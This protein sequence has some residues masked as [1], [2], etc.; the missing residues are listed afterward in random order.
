MDRRTDIWTTQKPPTMA[1]ADASKT[2][3]LF[4]YVIL[5]LTTPDY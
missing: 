4:I 2:D 3:I 1:V 5:S